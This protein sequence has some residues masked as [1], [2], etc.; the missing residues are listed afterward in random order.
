[1][2]GRSAWQHIY[3]GR[4]H[5]WQFSEPWLHSKVPDQKTKQLPRRPPGERPDGPR[6]PQDFPRG[7]KEGKASLDMYFY[8]DIKRPAP[9]TDPMAAKILRQRGSL[10]LAPSCVRRTPLRAPQLFFA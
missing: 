5:V 10:P 1:M 9:T 8:V 7:L 6:R 3:S 4:H 2:S